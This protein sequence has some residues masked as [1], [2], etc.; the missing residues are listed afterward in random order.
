MD[1]KPF[2]NMEKGVYIYTHTKELVSFIPG[3]TYTKFTSECYNHLQQLKSIHQQMCFK[4]Y[5]LK[6]KASLE[7]SSPA[8]AFP[9]FEVFYPT[10]NASSSSLY[11]QDYVN[12]IDSHTSSSRIST[13]SA[14]SET[15][16]SGMLILHEP[17]IST[18]SIR[19]P[20]ES[21][22]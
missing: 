15:V 18:Q 10:R 14:T 4:F 1:V 16:F 13:A 12:L 20:L 11:P 8:I 5:Y 17:L 6:F 7:I 2:N 21:L 3:Q 9:E 19:F 22:F